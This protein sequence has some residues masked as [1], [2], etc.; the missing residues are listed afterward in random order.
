MAKLKIYLVPFLNLKFLLSFGIAWVI[1]NGW[2]YICLGLSIAFNIGWLKV[3]STTYIAFLYMPF[4]V[5]KIITIPLSI[6]FQEHL[7]PRDEKLHGQLIKMHIQAKND[8]RNVF[9]KIIT[10]KELKKMM[11]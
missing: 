8:F 6:F 10:R 2:S 9:K 4:T 5:E 7:F 3:V 1:T 11:E